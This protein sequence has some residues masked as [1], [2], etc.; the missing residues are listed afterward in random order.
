MPQRRFGPVV[1]W[2]K[3]HVKDDD[4]NSSILKNEPQKCMKHLAKASDVIHH[5]LEL[6]FGKDAKEENREKM[7]RLPQWIFDDFDTSD[8]FGGMC[9][10][11]LECIRSDVDMR[12]IK[13]FLISMCQAAH[14][15]EIVDSE[16]QHMQ[17]FQAIHQRLLNKKLIIYPKIYFHPD[18]VKSLAEV[19]LE[20][21]KNIA[22]SHCAVV[23]EDESD[24]SHTVVPNTK[25]MAVNSDAD[26]DYYQLSRIA[27]GINGK[28]K[29]ALVHWWFFPDS[30]NEWLP[31]GDFKRDGN[32]P[33]SSP[34]RSRASDSGS[35]FR[36]CLRWLDD[37]QI[38]NEWMNE[39][40][41]KNRLS[42]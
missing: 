12:D 32:R 15:G 33:F 27:N 41:S 26:Q 9:N 17:L 29:L 5:S 39:E 1:E 31:L 13:K 11:L 16:S 37:T 22:T 40:V 23:V 8:C 6:H 3:K 30:Y 20:R 19:D 10:M 2:L 21:Y 38:F 35:E 42:F 24:A 36:V 25:A 34:R 14:D 7:V 4:L 18:L 28:D